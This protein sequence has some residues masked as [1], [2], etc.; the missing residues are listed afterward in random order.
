MDAQPA[1]TVHQTSGAMTSA[2]VTHDTLACRQPLDQKLFSY[3]TLNDWIAAGI[4]LGRIERT[5]PWDIADWWIAGERFSHGTRKRI[6]TASS[7][8]GPKYESCMTMASVA[9]K[10]PPTS[11]RLDLLLG[12]HQAVQG[13]PPD[14]AN[15]LLDY[16]SWQVWSVARIKHE[17]TRERA[18]FHAVK[19]SGDIVADINDLIT[20]HK[21]FNVVL[22][23]V[24]WG[25][26]NATRVGG[27]GH[28]YTG[29]PFDRTC[30]LGAQLRKVLAPSAYLFLWSPAALLC[31]A[32]TVVE[33]WGFEY[34]TCAV[35]VKPRDRGMGSYFRTHHELL[36][37]GVSAQSP[38]FHGK[39][40]SV[41][42][43]PRGRHSE[44][45]DIFHTV[46][47]RAVPGPYLELFGRK[48]RDGW[49]VVGDQIVDVDQHQRGVGP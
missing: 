42:E 22:A 16:A 44:K 34:K 4:P 28:H 2:T 6:V 1:S 18:G 9:R 29:I 43:A 3:P 39:P 48:K 33:A 32:M 20:Q 40:D 10:F 41:I 38:K 36:L 17:A 47:E 25:S 30:A 21:R 26:I 14:T 27:F 7:W 31:R 19:P 13:L 49:T 5:N 15:R 11:R 46:I 37:L 45:P 24:P 8:K 35:W 23:D 12:H